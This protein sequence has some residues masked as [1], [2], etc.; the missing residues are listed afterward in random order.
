[1]TW[2]SASLHCNPF[3]SSRAARIFRRQRSADFQSAVSRVCNPQGVR[4]GGRAGRFRRPADCKSAI[5]QSATLRYLGC[6]SA[7][8]R[9]P[10]S[11]ADSFEIPS[12]VQ[13]SL[14]A[15]ARDFRRQRAC[16]PI[17]SRQNRGK[18]TPPPD[19]VRLSRGK[20][21]RNS[22]AV[23]HSWKQPPLP[24]AAETYSHGNTRR[25]PPFTR[26]SRENSARRRNSRPP[27]ADSAVCSRPQHPFPAGSVRHI[28][29]P[30]PR[31]H[32]IAHKTRPNGVS[33]SSVQREDMEWHISDFCH[34]FPRF[35][36]GVSPHF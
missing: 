32:Q 36:F 8:L 31:F 30:L 33:Q 7:A 1:M 3:E 27:P 2:F 5:R 14:P 35:S 21:F 22:V 29:P 28:C 13:P 17:P 19:F 11:F 9:S 16:A 12:L 10:R 26:R 6:G 4:P 25:T 20:H 18:H 23:S 34:R 15:P 24:P